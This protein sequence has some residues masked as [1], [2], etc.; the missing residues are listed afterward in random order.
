MDLK[1]KN[2]NNQVGIE[3]KTGNVVNDSAS[4]QKF[5]QQYNEKQDFRK[6]ADWN[7]TS[8]LRNISLIHNRE[9]NTKEIYESLRFWCNKIDKLSLNLE[10]NRGIGI[11]NQEVVYSML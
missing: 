2:E 10:E 7:D 6:T 1:I 5:L 3:T 9:V 8:K 4:L 11:K